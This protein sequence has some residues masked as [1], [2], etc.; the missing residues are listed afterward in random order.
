MEKYFAGKPVKQTNTKYPSLSII[1]KIHNCKYLHINLLLQIHSSYNRLCY[2]KNFGPKG[3]GFG[4]T[5]SV[6][7]LMS[8]GVGQ[9][10][11]E[12]VP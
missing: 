8:G 6:P 12:R 10:S 4:G 2:G 7:A 9:Y 11:E 1:G 3:Y 5:G